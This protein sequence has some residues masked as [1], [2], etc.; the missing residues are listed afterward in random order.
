MDGAFV[1][2]GADGDLCHDP[3]VPPPGAA[4]TGTVTF[5]FT[6]VEGSTALWAG[7][8]DAM[9]ASLAVHDELLR[10]AIE[11]QDGYVFSTAGDSFAV[12]FH[13][14]SDA[15]RA[16][17]H[18]QAELG[19]AEWPGPPLRVRMGVHLGE[20]EERGGDYFGPVV[21]TAARVEAAGHGG[22][23]LIT[24]LVCAAAAVPDVVDLGVRSLRDVPEPI[25][26]FQ[27]GAGDFPPLRVVDPELSNLP[28]RRRA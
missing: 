10:R 28:A 18:A 1:R 23:I 24:E 26:L 9:S 6:D 16:A 27:V 5:L 15:V 12:A 4:P 11:E 19:S 22:Q 3:P 2:D 7:D 20:S 25:R 21:N 17:V 8:S 14:A 13:R